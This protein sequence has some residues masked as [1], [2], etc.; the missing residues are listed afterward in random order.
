MKRISAVVVSAGL[1]AA[2]FAM[3]PAA[4]AAP[5]GPAIARESDGVRGVVAGELSAS[6]TLA[7]TTAQ[8]SLTKSLG[9]QRS[10]NG[11]AASFAK[12]QPATAHR[13]AVVQWA[14]AQ[15]FR[16]LHSSRFLVSVAGP[17]S[18]LAAALGTT[19]HRVGSYTESISAPVVPAELAGHVSGVVGLDNRPV[20]RQHSASFGPADVRAMSNNVVRNSTAGA[21]VTVGSVNFAPWVKS[22]LTDWAADPEADGDPAKAL[23]V[24]PGQITEVPV[25]GFNTVGDGTDPGSGEVD[26]DAEALL[27]AA[28]AAKQRMYFGDNSD[29]GSLAIWDK[30]A[31]DAAQGLLQVAT[32]SWG[33]CESMFTANELDAEATAINNLVAAGVTLFAASGDAGAYD[34]SVDDPDGTGVDNSLAVDFPASNPNVVG[35]GGTSTQPGATPLTYTHEAWG[36]V[37]VDTTP[38]STYQGSGSGGGFS[39]YFS[40]PAWQPVSAT[41]GRQVPDIAGLGDPDT[42]YIGFLTTD[43]QGTGSPYGDYS[44]LGGTSLASPLAAAGLATVIGSVSPI[45]GLGNIL[46]ALYATPSATH[47]VVGNG[48]GYYGATAGFDHVTGLGVVDWTAFTSTLGIPDPTLT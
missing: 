27:G 5:K 48:N 47:D 18:A 30:M 16:V 46:P 35:V 7:Q 11:R 20:F 14:T 8:R 28:P 37:V 31:T 6:F 12:T 33:G 23:T 19:V 21:G 9:S 25:S 32:T 3:T 22:D 45:A 1:V 24:A 15:G 2:S 42:G 43:W 17:S 29:A 34:C 40:K 10:G 36:P 38:D 44:L 41:P 26:L 13:H 4:S 39:S